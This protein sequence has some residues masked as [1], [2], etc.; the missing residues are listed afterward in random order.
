MSF[1]VTLKKAEKQQRRQ[2]EMRMDTRLGEDIKERI[3]GTPLRELLTVRNY[4]QY[5]A[6]P[7]GKEEV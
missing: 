6:Y 3:S 4:G 5:K 7:N 2:L 1:I